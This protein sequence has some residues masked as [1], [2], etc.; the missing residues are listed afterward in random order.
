MQN[1]FPEARRAAVERALLAAF[2]TS[3]LDGAQTVGGGLSGAGVWRIRV[4]GINYLLRIENG[5]DKLRDPVRG[6][7]CMRTA[8]DAFLAPRV[9]YADP[10][11]GVSISEFV[12]P[13]SLAMD[14][15]GSGS[16]LIV[17]LAQKVRLLHETPP[18]PTLIDYLDGLDELIFEHRR[19]DI[20][21]P[22]ATQELFARYGELRA[23]YQTRACDLVSSHN[24]LN[25]GNVIYDGQR[26]WLV[27]FEAA[28]LAD[29]FVDLATIANWFT[30][31]AASAD[32]LLQTYFG[33]APEPQERARFDLMRLVNHVFC[34]VIF[35]NVTCAERPDGLEDRTLTGPRLAQLRA[36]LG[37]GGFDMMAWENRVTYGKA[38]LAE[39]LQGLRD[40]A[41]N[42]A[43][44]LAA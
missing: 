33:R 37:A 27:D 29:R 11:D 10:T 26:L 35:L 30:G 32:T 1:P 8:A 3:E 17:D 40:P 23:S 44:A 22:A 13:R 25:P 4:G 34:G 5:R 7:A 12:Q 42:E 24:D 20:L 15:P 43:M 9:R 28:F 38:R 31:D 14:Y 41:C 18:F 2:G 16:A 21:E 39:A 36:R 6:Y 19:L